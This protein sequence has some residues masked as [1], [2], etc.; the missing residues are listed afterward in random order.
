M[1]ELMKLKDLMP[2]YYAGVYEIDV[3]QQIEQPMLDN[4]QSLIDQEQNNHFAAIAN[5][6]GISIFESLFGIVDT[7][8][9][10]LETRR[11]NVIMRLLPPKPVTIMYMR[12]L[13]S[14]LNINATL[15]VDAPNFHVN[16]EAQTTD[17]S[18]MK[19]LTVLLKRL[20]PANMTFTAF[21]LQQTSTGGQIATGT[22]ALYNATI[23]NKGG[24]A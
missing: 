2:D 17:N 21:N 19:R 3:I 6:D 9:Q 23:S 16:V 15:L 10:D 11:Y 18:A 7:A 5:E 12:E 1:A 8:G 24:T 14:T 13:L 4:L 20:L 22:D